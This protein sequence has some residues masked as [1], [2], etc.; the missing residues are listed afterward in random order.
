MGLLLL[1]LFV[2]HV[3]IGV[4]V[5]AVF[6]RKQYNPPTSRND[7]QFPED[8]DGP[9]Q[10]VCSQQ[11]SEFNVHAVS[12]SSLCMLCVVCLMCSWFVDV[13]VLGFLASVLYT[14]SS[15]HRT[16]SLV[17]LLNTTKYILVFCI[18]NHQL[19]PYQGIRLRLDILVKLKLIEGTVFRLGIHVRVLH[20]SQEL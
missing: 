18:Y 5:L 2:V 15:M 11:P 20:D 10:Y 3:G 12:C 6:I 17:K 14:C 8:N 9:A 1:I 13:R 7:V 19:Q 4:L 16:C